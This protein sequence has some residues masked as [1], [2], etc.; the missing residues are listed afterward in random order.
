MSR[1]VLITGATG[2]LGRALASALGRDMDTEVFGLARGATRATDGLNLHWL[3]GD[4]I[5]EEFAAQAVRTARPTHCFH[6]AGQS[7]EGASWKQPW[8]T[9]QANVRGQ[10]N[11][12]EAL[13]ALAPDCRTLISSSSAVYGFMSGPSL[14]ETEPLNPVSPYGVSKAAQDMMARQYAVSHDLPV[15]VARNFNIIGP[16]QDA[17]FAFSSFA[18]QIARAEKGEQEPVLE[19]GNLE[20]ERDFLDVGD[21]LEAWDLLIARGQLG[22][23]YNVGSGVR[24]RLQNLVD[25][26]LAQ[27]RVPMNARKAAARTRSLATDPPAL[28]A[29]ITRLQALGRWRP[30]RPLRRT[31]SNLLD[32]WRAR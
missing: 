14:S 13:A 7:R 8:R 32:Y 18:C 19:T 25:E 1:R 16:G 9:Y 17:S 26:M 23:A 20:V 4:L 10:L 6:L 5:E 2:F 29:D 21:M 22:Q 24:Y 30:R 11:L 27:A 3:A 31:L 12:L 15:I 28:Q